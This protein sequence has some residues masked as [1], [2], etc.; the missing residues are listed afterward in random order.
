VELFIPDA[1]PNEHPKLYVR[2]TPG[3]ICHYDDDHTHEYYH[4]HHRYFHFNHHHH[5]RHY[6][7]N[8]H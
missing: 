7:L 6:L 4:T 8:Y 2:P 3:I 5:R 1:Y